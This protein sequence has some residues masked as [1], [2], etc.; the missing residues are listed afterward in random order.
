M[1]CDII[2]FHEKQEKH[3]ATHICYKDMRIRTE[4]LAGILALISKLVD[5]HCFVAGVSMDGW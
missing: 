4:I 3:D 5:V 2:G 1:R